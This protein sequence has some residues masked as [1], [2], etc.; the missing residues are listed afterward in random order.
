MFKQLTAAILLVAFVLQTFNGAFV[1]VS[2]YTN[3]A[4][5]AKNCVN[6]AKPK[7]HCNGKCQM[8]KK[9]QEEENKD[10]QY[11]QRKNDNKN[12]VLYFSTNQYNDQLMSNAFTLSYSPF[13]NRTAKE[14]AFDFF[15]PP[16]A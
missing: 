2:Y 10:K 1:L 3:T 4:T 11:P 16:K 15:Q 9:M 13:K 8:M 12:E 14:I 6:K 7:M 5:Y